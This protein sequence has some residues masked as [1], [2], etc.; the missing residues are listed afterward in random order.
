MRRVPDP[1]FGLIVQGHAIR[2]SVSLRRLTTQMSNSQP[3]AG[4]HIVYSCDAD[5][6]LK[7]GCGFSRRPASAR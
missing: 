7:H 6:L 4:H 1:A 5:R 3:A 2:S